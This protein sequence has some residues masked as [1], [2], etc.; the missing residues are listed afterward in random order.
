MIRRDWTRQLC[1]TVPPVLPGS[2]PLV[3]FCEENN[4]L[5]LQK[6]YYL[7]ILSYVLPH[8]VLTE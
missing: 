1:G 3:F 6:P 5:L 7:E 2:P 4:D 8:L